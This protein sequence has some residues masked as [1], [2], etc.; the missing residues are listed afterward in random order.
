MCTC[1]SR[2]I[3]TARSGRLRALLWLNEA[4]KEIAA[5]ESVGPPRAPGSINEPKR[6]RMEAWRV[7]IDWDERVPSHPLN[8]LAFSWKQRAAKRSE[9]QKKRA[10]AKTDTR[11]C[12]ADDGSN[13]ALRFAP[14]FF[15]RFAS[16]AS[17]AVARTSTAMLSGQGS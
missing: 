6:V 3:S 12:F 14:Y 9:H 4:V 17:R 15:F 16:F 11:W 2:S 8:K 10:P 1:N 13:A 7:E 5:S